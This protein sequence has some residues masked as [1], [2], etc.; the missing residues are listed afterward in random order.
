MRFV[1]VLALCSCSLVKLTADSTADVL[2]VAAPAN[3]MENDVQ[4]ARE[5]APGQLKTVEGFLMASPE[6]RTMLTLLAQGYCEYAF[7]F[8]QNDYEEL[9]M[10]GKTEEAAPI[11]ARA[12]NLFQR[13][14]NYGFKLLGGTWQKTFYGD[15]EAFEKRVKSTDGDDVP[16]MFWVAMGV[17]SA[18]DLNRDD[19]E[20]VAYLPKAQRLFQRVLE[21]DEAYYLG[22]AHI[23]LGMI[24]TA[25]GPAMGGDPEKGRKHF[26][27]AVE[28]TSGKYL[29]PKV[30]MALAYGGITQ[31][32][33]LFHTELEKVLQ[34][35]PA[36][37]PEERL[38]NELAHLRAKR[39]LAHE[40]EWF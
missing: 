4:F 38:P 1:V 8:L 32:R 19:I 40:K 12:T 39:Y 9:A 26:E 18:I 33:E 34:T 16:G 2:A 14:A 30:L 3:N 20:M 23:A 28:L 13:C 35:S 17:T 37:W 36:I 24:L 5:A 27:R 7:A 11:A 25:Q 31:N 15:S 22:G 6:N 29:M 21:L 10:A